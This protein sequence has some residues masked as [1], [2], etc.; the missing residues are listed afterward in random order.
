MSDASKTALLPLLLGL[1]DVARL[2]GLSYSHVRK[3]A[4][5]VQPPLNFPPILQ[6]GGRRVVR[7]ADLDAWVASLTA[8]ETEFAS[9]TPA[10]AD[11]SS[12]S[13]MPTRQRGRP[14]KSQQSI[15]SRA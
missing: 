6:V 10:G 8:P 7:R 1:K 11:R 5:G 9:M 13:P 14:R 4:H 3:Y 15:G 2:L 12:A